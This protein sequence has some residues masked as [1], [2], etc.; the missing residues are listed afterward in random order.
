MKSRK[1][2]LNRLTA[3]LFGIV[4]WLGVF[5]VS[6]RWLMI[7]AD[8]GHAVQYIQKVVL[9]NDD[10][11]T[12]IILNNNWR[13]SAEFSGNIKVWWN[14]S[15]DKL[16][17]ENWTNCVDQVKLWSLSGITSTWISQW[18]S[19]FGRGD[20]SG[21][22]VL[23]G[24]D[25][26]PKIWTPLTANNICQYS[27][28]KIICN[29]DPNTL[30]G[31]GA[32]G[33]FYLTGGSFNSSNRV[34]TLNVSG[35]TSPV[36]IT[37]ND[38]LTGGTNLDP[39]IE[40]MGL[41]WQVCIV[42][43]SN[44][45]NCN[46]IPSTFSDTNYYVQSGFYNKNTNKITLYM[47]GTSDREIYLTGVITGY[48]DLTQNYIPIF[49]GG[50]LKDSNI[51]LDNDWTLRITNDFWYIWI[52]PDVLGWDISLVSSRDWTNHSHLIWMY[53]DNTISIA[54][55]A[56]LIKW[57][58]VSIWSYNPTEKLEI[59]GNMKSIGS[60]DL[61]MWWSNFYGWEFMWLY[62]NDSSDINNIIAWFVGDW[63]SINPNSRIF[64]GG[65]IV[66]RT[67]VA[68]WDATVN[69]ASSLGI[70]ESVTANWDY[71]VAMGWYTITNWSNSVAMGDSTTAYWISS[72]AMGYRTLASWQNSVAMGDSTTAYWQNSLAMGHRTLASWQN[73]VAM[74]DS[75][76]AN[77]ENSLAIWK[78]NV[79][80]T[81][82]L[83]EIGYWI[84]TN[85]RKNAMTVTSTSWYV[86]IGV[87]NPTAPLE[88]FDTIT[89]TGKTFT[90]SANETRTIWNLNIW[91]T[92]IINTN[93]KWW[94]LWTWIST[95]FHLSK[96]NYLSITSWD[97]S[98]N[99][100]F[101]NNNSQMNVMIKWKDS[102][103]LLYTDYN[104]KNVGIWTKPNEEDVKLDVNGAIQ[105]G[106]NTTACSA[107]NDWWKIK[108]D[109][110]KLWVC[111]WTT[112]KSLKVD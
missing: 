73:S 21:L 41:E 58:N 47:S 75:T 101:N 76:T 86:G 19:A 51:I 42:N 9:L 93:Y 71:S 1:S 92:R 108:Y 2:S 90:I 107:A 105:I 4:L 39:I 102:S 83:F 59:N 27:G 24:T 63:A 85:N 54:N 34:L 67:G 38:I 100:V 94:D 106:N 91:E 84:D 95:A 80:L 5:I 16:C 45:I 12:G 74:G 11:S 20:H 112:W 109:D 30:G 110:Y 50:D 46:Y 103:T 13:G 18:N 14:L 99:I 10:F 48:S 77:W 6:V 87:D 28:S 36:T 3:L 82:S 25:L 52:A 26:D 32:D 17:N 23:I 49:S 43:S 79:W 68:I 96:I 31:G 40:T 88:V 104:G 57:G 69:W 98:Q 7:Q 70:G 62:K 60:Y 35:V 22:Y 97:T 8:L 37:L 53:S 89:I 78:Y 81:N 64:A 111:N 66:V 56:V 55:D 29:I 61:I 72:L 33:N 15:S 65:T 44:K